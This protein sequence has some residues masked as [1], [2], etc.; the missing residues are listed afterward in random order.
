MQHK[1]TFEC[2]ASLCNRPR[3][4][5]RISA[6]HISSYLRSTRE[7]RHRNTQVVREAEGDSERCSWLLDRMQN[8]IFFECIGGQ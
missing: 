2:F 4:R 1:T 6:L 5:R 8:M 3:Y 7:R